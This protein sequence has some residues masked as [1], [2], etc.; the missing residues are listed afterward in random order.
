MKQR[1]NPSGI[2]FKKGRKD[3]SS[4]LHV[5]IGQ[6]YLQN[7]LHYTPALPAC[8]SVVR[9]QVNSRIILAGRLKM[10]GELGLLGPASIAPF[11]DPNLPMKP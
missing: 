1:A 5:F 3:A 9:E 10:T 6:V 2:S 4:Q 8:I 11:T 7:S